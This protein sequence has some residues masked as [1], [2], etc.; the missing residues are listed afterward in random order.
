[1]PAPPL[2]LPPT[3]PPPVRSWPRRLLTHGLIAV[4]LAI[5]VSGFIT[6]TMGGDF[7]RNLVFSLC[8]GGVIQAMVELGRHG[9]SAWLRARGRTD[10]ALQADWPGWALM[11]P[12]VVVSALTGQT[13]GHWLGSRITG[14]PVTLLAGYDSRGMTLVLLLTLALPVLVTYYFWARTQLAHAAAQ[15]EA[16]S[17]LAS[18]TQLRLLQSQLEPHMLF[19]TLANLRVLIALDADRAQDML[20]RLINFL[21]ATLAA[22][23]SASHPLAAEFDRVAD[24]LALMA[25]RMGPR[26]AVSLDLP[27]A[28]RPCQVPPLLLQP[29]VENCIKHGLEPKVAGGR[30]TVSARQH[31][32]RLV[33][34]VRDTGVGLPQGQASPG[35]AGADAALPSHAADAAG[36]FGNHQIH[37]RLA[38]LYG[39][40]AHFELLAPADAE[41]GTLA[42]IS[43]PLP[44]DSLT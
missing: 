30:I 8:I 29:L 9:L 2:Y 15:A 17:R 1:M 24:Y 35:A 44:P 6:L 20:D 33:L 11:A 36:G 40:A 26:L 34:E 23:R 4:S 19:N 39:N 22:S 37:Q 42:R 31:G 27:D 41:G 13:L 10:P 5:G 18:E 32:Q 12:W 21:R 14:T 25:V 28:L 38:A 3:R 16:A 43:L 7:P